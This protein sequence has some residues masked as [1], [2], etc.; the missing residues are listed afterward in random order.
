[1]IDL[2]IENAFV[3]T[4]GP[5]RRS[6]FGHL[7]IHAGHLTHVAPGPATVVA[8]ERIDATGQIVIPGLL[9]AHLHPGAAFFRGLINDLTIEENDTDEFVGV[10]YGRV[11]DDIVAATGRLTFQE[12]LSGGTTGFAVHEYL[13]AEA[14]LEALGAIGFT[15]TFG[16]WPED[17]TGDGGDKVA[18]G[19]EEAGLRLAILGPNE[20]SPDF[21]Y[22]HLRSL[23]NLAARYDA[24]IH[25]HVHETADRVA[26]A[27]AQFSKSPLRILEETGVL[28]HLYAV[29]CCHLDGTDI[30]LLASTGVPVA[31]TPASEAML[32]DGVTPVVELR[33][34]GIVLGLGTDGSAWTGTEDMFREMRALALLNRAHGGPAAVAAWDAFEMATIGSARAMRI[35]RSVGSIEVGKRADLTFVS[36]D[37]P[38]FHPVVAARRTNLVELVAFAATGRDV[39]RVLIKGAQ[40]Y[41]RTPGFDRAAKQEAQHAWQRLFAGLLDDPTQLRTSPPD[42]RQGMPT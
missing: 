5:E 36:L 19:V 31:V 38:H 9:N 21:T 35:D 13:S 16:V 22:E 11:T 33:E 34:R 20:D 7:G 23:R 4:S 3:V 39:A 37:S 30:D 14:G 40:V 8:R 27:Y 18:A 26:K 25:M 28:A 29:H 2:L 17:L 24:Q 42:Q 10:V 6:F 41:D 1:M 15:G 32:G 12:A